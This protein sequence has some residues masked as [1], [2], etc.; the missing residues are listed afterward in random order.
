M[1][2]TG[3][4]EVKTV[5]WLLVSSGLFDNAALRVLGFSRDM[6]DWL[7]SVPLRGVSGGESGCS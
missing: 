5:L 3:S 7:A 2:V 4:L 6:D 1:T